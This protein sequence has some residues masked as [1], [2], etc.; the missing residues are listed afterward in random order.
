MY[1]SIPQPL[2]HLRLMRIIVSINTLKVFIISKP[3]N[4]DKHYDNIINNDEVCQCLS[5]YSIRSFY[6]LCFFLYLPFIA[7][8]GEVNSERL[9]NM[10]TITEFEAQLLNDQ[11]GILT[12][13]RYE[14]LLYLDVP[15]DDELFQES[16]VYV[17]A[18]YLVDGEK[19]EL[20]SYSLME[21][22]ENQV[23][24][25]ELEDDEV[26]MI[27]DFCEKYYAEVE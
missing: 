12:G 16:G 2:P 25:F 3:I 26:K 11:F 24:D 8:I 17:R 22:G 23:L 1:S 10:I 20:L 5:L 6:M 9:L 18:L 19:K 13:N 15:E 14:F 7:I 21:R 27:T 4:K